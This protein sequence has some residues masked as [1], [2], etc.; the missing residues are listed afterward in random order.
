MITFLLTMVLAA[1]AQ[2]ASPL[3]QAA[4]QDS[5]QKEITVVGEK[6]TEEPEAVKVCHFVKKTGSIRPERV[7]GT[8]STDKDRE[9]RNKEEMEEISRNRVLN[10]MNRGN[11]D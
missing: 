10:E 2:D 4:N 3:P 9:A 6:A 1:A 8:V 7:C 11:R 5:P